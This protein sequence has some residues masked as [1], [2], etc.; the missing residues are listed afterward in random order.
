MIKAIVLH[1]RDPGFDSRRQHEISQ[2]R[3]LT[4]PTQPCEESYVKLNR[5]SLP[6]YIPEDSKLKVLSLTG[7]EKKQYIQYYGYNRTI[8]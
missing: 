8:Q 3:C 1:D 5:F 6:F 2:C 7:G 4:G